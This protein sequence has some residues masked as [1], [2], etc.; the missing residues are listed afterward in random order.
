MSEKK[1]LRTPEV[2]YKTAR[3]KS[4]LLRLIRDGYLIRG[5]HWLKGPYKSSPITWDMDALTEFF[6]QQAPMPAPTQN[7]QENSNV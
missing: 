6:S 5:T 4:Q 1:W 2:A 3:S 7:N